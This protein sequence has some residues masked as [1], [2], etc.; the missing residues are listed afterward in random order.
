MSDLLISSA[1]WSRLWFSVWESSLTVIISCGIGGGLAWLEHNK[2]ATPARWFWLIM[3]LPI[4][5][6]STL[7]AVGYV[8]VYG[9]MGYFNQLLRSL[10]FPTL[11]LLYTPLAVIA[12][13]CFYNIPLFYLGIRLRLTTAHYYLEDTARILG[14]NPAQIFYNI[15]LP[16]LRSTIIG[17]SILVFLYSFMSFGL[18]LIIGGIQYQTIEVYIYQLITNY[19]ALSQA[20]WLA[21]LQWIFLSIIVV[22]GYRNSRLFL[23]AHLA[24]LEPT[25]NHYW[26]I[27]I[28]RLVMA[29][30]IILPLF[31]IVL[32]SDITLFHKLF[33]GTFSEALVRSV[34]LGIISICIVQL[35]AICLILY[36]PKYILPMSLG[37]IALSPVTIAALLRLNIQP[38]IVAV[39]IA[40][41]LLLLPLTLSIVYVRWNSWSE[42]FNETLTLLGKNTW[43]HLKI[44]LR[45]LKPALLQAAMIGYVF[46][47][48][49][50]AISKILSPYSQPTAMIVSMQLINSY[51]FAIGTT[52]LGVLLICIMV[53][54]V[55]MHRFQGRYE[56]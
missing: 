7:V 45:Y 51:H 52:A 16:R 49:D 12:G 28:L 35:V 19:F 46:V 53:S 20:A 32:N 36:L 47:L 4:F 9:N 26:L 50:L 13:N 41:S 38:H 18:P 30:Y 44:K 27:H 14:A 31:S 6:P 1:V 39:I 37:I 21:L 25:K 48:G 5:L 15:T 11:H 54:I 34:S 33:S 40:Y 42:H 17:L 56:I 55:L 8:G 10:H 2:K 29:S 23:E 24:T 43:L 3:I 22:V